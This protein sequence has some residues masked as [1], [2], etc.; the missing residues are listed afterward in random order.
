[1]KIKTYV[2]FIGL[3]KSKDGYI[4]CCKVCKSIDSK[5]LYE[6]NKNKKK[7]IVE[8]KECI[9]CKMLLQ[10]RDFPKDAGNCSGIRSICK[11]CYRDYHKNYR[12]QKI[13]DYHKKYYQ[14]VV[15]ADPER[16][17]KK[18]QYA[19]DNIV[20]TREYKSKCERK[21]RAMKLKVEE[22]YTI[23]NAQITKNAFENK[24]FNC[25]SKEKLCIDHHKPISKG[26]ALTLKN[27]V[28]LCNICNIKKSNKMPEEFYDKEK[29]EKLNKILKKLCEP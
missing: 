28:L 7:D 19:K 20:K 15:K 2:I 22:N 8:E 10:Y 4:S 11:K 12:D 18:K 1:M 23:E 16:M 5:K 6:K 13:P 29:L 27:A 3:K 14:D 21:R 24:C 26:F 25:G 17:R 9:K